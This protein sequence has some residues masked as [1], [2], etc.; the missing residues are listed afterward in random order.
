MAVAQWVA[1]VLGL[2]VAFVLY[3]LRKSKRLSRLIVRAI[4]ALT[5]V[6]DAWRKFRRT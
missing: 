2:V 6:R 5:E 4:D 1:C 3:V